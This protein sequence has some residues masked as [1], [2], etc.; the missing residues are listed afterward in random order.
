MDQILEQVDDAVRIADDVAVDAKSKE[1]QDK[2]L[3]KIL[4]VAA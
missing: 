3:H 2:L 4:Q 1:K